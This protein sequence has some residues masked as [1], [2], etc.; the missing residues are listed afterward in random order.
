MTQ[1]QQTRMTKQRMVILEELRNVHSHPT[2]D[3]VYGMVRQRLPRISLGTVYRNL[4]LLAESGDILKLESAGAQKRFDGNVTPHQHV[5]CTQCGRVGDVMEP[6]RLPDI[7][8]AGAPGFIILSG[9]IEFEGVCEACAS[10][11]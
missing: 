9:R 1:P 6:V 3:E 2:A 5:R 11:N 8:G 10:K 4:D 7:S